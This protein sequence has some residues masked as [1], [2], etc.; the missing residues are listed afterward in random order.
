LVDTKQQTCDSKSFVEEDNDSAADNKEDEDGED[1]KD[2]KD[3]AYD[4]KRS[5]GEDAGKDSY[6]G[7]KPEDEADE[8]DLDDYDSIDENSKASQAL[9]SSRGINELRELVF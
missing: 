4:D 1:D 2:N 9:G 6:T 5:S 8:A 3:T 7:Y